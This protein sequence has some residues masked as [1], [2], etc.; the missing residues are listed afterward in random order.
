MREK[1]RIVTCCPYTLRTECECQ[2]FSNSSR[3]A[4][5]VDTVIFPTYA[6]E[7]RTSEKSTFRIAVFNGELTFSIRLTLLDT[8]M[9]FSRPSQVEANIKAMPV[10]WIEWRIIIVVLLRDLEQWKRQM[11]HWKVC[12]SNCSSSRSTTVRVC[13]CKWIPEVQH[14]SRISF[15]LY[16]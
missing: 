13:V 11:N 8:E 12:W 14:S 15:L 7:R 4:F 3:G 9:N 2:R 5:R 6:H 16:N 1:W 10:Q